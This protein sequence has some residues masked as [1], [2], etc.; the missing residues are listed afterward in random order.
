[1][2]FLGRSWGLGVLTALAARYHHLLLLL[3]LV[4]Y[5]ICWGLLWWLC[6][7]GGDNLHNNMLHSLLRVVLLGEEEIYNLS[8]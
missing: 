4:T 5:C 7:V 8:D 3:L 2:A 6:W 1:M